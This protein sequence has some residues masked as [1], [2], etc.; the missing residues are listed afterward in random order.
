M[1][2]NEWSA[3]AAKPLQHTTVREQK[4][5]LQFW[6]VWGTGR[7]GSGSESADTDRRSF[8]DGKCQD[9]SSA[10]CDKLHSWQP[11]Q[12]EGATP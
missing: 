12:C 11:S 3:E 7:I 5:K 1:F 9:P 8:G 10:I 6:D 4:T 2:H